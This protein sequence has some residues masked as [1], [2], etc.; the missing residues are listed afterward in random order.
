MNGTDIYTQEVQKDHEIRKSSYSCQ[1][2]ATIYKSRLVCTTNGDVVYGCD[3]V[4]LM[5]VTLMLPSVL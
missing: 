5:N 3:F 4:I 2:R 1:K